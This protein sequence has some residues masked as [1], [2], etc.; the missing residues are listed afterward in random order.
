[1]KIFNKLFILS[2]FIL[3]YSCTAGYFASGKTK[4]YQG[5]YYLNYNNRS[6]EQ[7]KEKIKLIMADKNW[8]KTKET[9]NELKYEDSSNK[10][11]NLV[12][13]K[14]SG[15]NVDFIFGKDK[16]TVNLSLSG[17]YDHGTE[18]NANKIFQEF[19]GKF[20]R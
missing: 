13:F 20:Y 4:S 14:Y 18:A 12:L 9:A 11:E 3:L 8:N 5:E 17:N 19:E 10:A 15:S 1:M 2:S 7:A 6:V 16:I